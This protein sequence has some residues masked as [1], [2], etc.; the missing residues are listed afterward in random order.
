MNEQPLSLEAE[1]ARVEE[2]ARRNIRDGRA[3]LNA[4]LD[5]ARRLTG[6]EFAAA[7]EFNARL[8]TM[9]RERDHCRMLGQRIRLWGD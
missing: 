1:A 4:L 3:T 7:L 6:Q 9:L 8:C 2:A 5:R